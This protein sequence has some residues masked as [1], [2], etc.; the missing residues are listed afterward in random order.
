M[1]KHSGILLGVSENT[2]QIK[3]GKHV[4]IIKYHNDDPH[5]GSRIIYFDIKFCGFL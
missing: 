4:E 3:Q 1:I 2:N 5:A